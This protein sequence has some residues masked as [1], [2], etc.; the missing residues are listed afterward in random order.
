MKS[1]NIM[2]LL[3]PGAIFVEKVASECANQ[4]LV[5]NK[6]LEK[7]DI[8]KGFTCDLYKS[9]MRSQDR[10][11][12]CYYILFRTNAPHVD[13]NALHHGLFLYNI[14]RMIENVE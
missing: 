4:L 13:T 9:F 2:W 12:P 7:S 11:L 8:T 5:K 10:V 14:I 1:G 3:H 6:I